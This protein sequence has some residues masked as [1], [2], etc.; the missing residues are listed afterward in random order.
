MKRS[1][2]FTSRS[3]LSL[4]EKRVVFWPSSDKFRD[5]CRIWNNYISQAPILVA[6]SQRWIKGNE[7]A[8]KSFTP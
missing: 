7:R 6:L 1:R 3:L 8:W 2:P 4:P 5:A